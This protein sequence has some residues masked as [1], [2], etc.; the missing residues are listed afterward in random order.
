[1]AGPLQ[2]VAAFARRRALV[3][4]LACVL[5]AAAVT[6]RTNYIADLSAFLP[7]TPT[8]EQAVLLDQL[9][10]GIAARLVLIGIEEIGRA[11]V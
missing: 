1:M 2:H 6:V 3:L 7:S 9:R 4:W 5:C 8:A 11:H 10:S